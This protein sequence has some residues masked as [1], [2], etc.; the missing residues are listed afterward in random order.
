MHRIPRL[1]PVLLFT[2]FTAG[3]S[4]PIQV[5]S[6]VAD[7]ISLFTTEKTVSDHG[8][9]MAMDKDCAV[10][11]GLGGDEI[12][13]DEAKGTMMTALQSGPAASPA[14]AGPSESSAAAGRWVYT[15]VESV[16]KE[17]LS[18]I[19]AAAVKP[20]SDPRRPAARQPAFV[21]ALAESNSF[22]A[23]DAAT[24][25]SIANNVKTAK[26]ARPAAAAKPGQ[27]S[28]GGG[29]KGGLHFVLASFSI[30][31]NA[32]K[33]VRLNAGLSPKVVTVKVKNRAMHRVVVGPFTPERRKTTRKRLADSGFASAW[34]IRLQ[35][36]TGGAMLAALPERAGGS[37]F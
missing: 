27:A 15:Q 28:Q 31:G 10:W 11:R 17:V 22:A 13:K 29:E 20:S 33:L 9:S 4:L 37:G 2:L 32:E 23:F 21:L 30:R 25:A 26:Q 7:G 5:A 34:G 35:P 19:P 8:I 12:C 36:A 24:A 16:E 1:L 14:A 6:L 18:A 3:C